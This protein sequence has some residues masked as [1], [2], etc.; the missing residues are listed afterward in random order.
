[1]HL[2]YHCSVC[3]AKI[4]TRYVKPGD[5]I[6]CRSCNSQIIVPASVVETDESPTI[7]HKEKDRSGASQISDGI[8]V[9]Q[10]MADE[11]EALKRN[12]PTPWGMLSIV[13]FII[14][15][16]VLCVLLS[17]L[18]VGVL[19][20][21]LKA[22]GF[23]CGSESCH[24]DA[25]EAAEELRLYVFLIS[26]IVSQILAVILI[27]HSVVRRHH[28]HFFKALHLFRLSKAELFRY[29]SIGAV[30]AVLALI[31]AWVIDSTLLDWLVPEEMPISKYTEAGY[32]VLAL[33]SISVIIAPIA[34]EIVFRGYLFTGLR[35]KLGRIA[36]IIIVT[37]DAYRGRMQ[38]RLAELPGVR[39]ER[40]EKMG[41][42]RRNA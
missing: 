40:S 27:H 31:L 3:G 11:M 14:L 28:N 19:S 6:V 29:A 5:L 18:M 34:E 22:A 41:S 26:M 15:Y 32:L 39:V 42:G 8:S 2:K 9:L 12:L 37:N 25:P 17:C 16:F 10:Q 21:T 24:A 20:P 33:F 36:S 4:V 38:E 35:Y 30:L 1:M 23:T 7:L 13:K